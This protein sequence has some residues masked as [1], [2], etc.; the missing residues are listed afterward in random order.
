MKNRKISLMNAQTPST[1]KWKNKML[2]HVVEYYSAIKK[3]AVSI[4]ATI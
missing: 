3:D 4:L 1:D 2:V